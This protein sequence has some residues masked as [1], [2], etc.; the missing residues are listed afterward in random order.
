M[1]I[2]M[3]HVNTGKRMR[4]TLESPDSKPNT[5][6]FSFSFASPS[7]FINKK[8][9]AEDPRTQISKQ[10]NEHQNKKVHLTSDM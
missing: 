1:S 2:A 5:V 3:Q 7:Q 8:R 9:L 4:I 6:S 10:E